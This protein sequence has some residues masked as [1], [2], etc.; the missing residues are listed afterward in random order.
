M[1]EVYLTERPE[2]FVEA[3]AEYIQEEGEE[4]GE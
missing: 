4:E 3:V 1:R 2:V